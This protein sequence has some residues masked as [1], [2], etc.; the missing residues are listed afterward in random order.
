[1]EY[2]KLDD[3]AIN[4]IKDLLMVT[5]WSFLEQLNTEG[6]FVALTEKLQEYINICAPRIKSRIPSKYATHSKWMTKGL[7]QSSRKLCKLRKKMT[8]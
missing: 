1:M 6:Q 7:L 5:D 2:R 3:P 4:N 8:R